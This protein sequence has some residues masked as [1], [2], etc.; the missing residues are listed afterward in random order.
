MPRCL[1]A[2]SVTCC[3]T[4]RRCDIARPTPVDAHHALGG[5]LRERAFLEALDELGAPYL[6]VGLGAAV[7]QGAPVVTEDIELWF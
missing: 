6:I 3:G 7:M 1:P 4:P 2:L 5:P